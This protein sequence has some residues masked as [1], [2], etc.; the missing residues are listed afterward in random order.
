MVGEVEKARN[1]SVEESSRV[2]TI[3]KRR[4]EQTDHPVLRMLD[5]L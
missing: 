2:E 5:E 3:G 1:T 4:G